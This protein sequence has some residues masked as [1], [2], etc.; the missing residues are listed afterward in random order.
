LSLFGSAARA[1]MR[2]GSDVDILV[3]FESGAHVGLFEFVRLQRHLSQLLGQAVDLV[4]PDAL[5]P[6]MRES[7]LREKV[8]AA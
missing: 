5:R 4:T 8:D 7:I 6:E 3:E 2:T 1:E